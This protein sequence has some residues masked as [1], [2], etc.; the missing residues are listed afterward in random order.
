MAKYHYDEAGNM[1][2]YF[3][4][5]FLALIL[6]PV[7]LLSFTPSK[8][9][10]DGCQC[11]PCVEQRKR[12]RSLSKPALSKKAYFLVFGWS[13]LGYVCY[14]VA[15]AKLDNKIYDPFEILGIKTG[16]AEKEIKS[17]YKKLSKLYHPDKVKATANNTIEAIQN[18]FVE[19]TKAYKSLTD[20]TIRENLEKFGHP[21]GRQDISMG[22]A[23]PQWI[24]E[25][26][27]N[28]W[29]LG[30]YGLL[31]GGA[32]PALVGRW[33]FGSRQK[34]KDGVNALSAAAF[35]KSL[36]E[37]STLEEV[38]GTFGKAFQ[39]ELSEKK[40]KPVP[41]LDQLEKTIKE[42]V[43]SKWDEVKKLCGSDA[44]RRKALVLIYAHL[45]RLDITSS[46]LKTEQ[47]EILLQTPH[48]LS[49][50]LNISISR[51]WLLPTLAI[52]RLHAYLAQALLPGSERLRFA[53]LPG[54]KTD[55]VSTLAPRAQDMG[56]F[57]HALEEKHDGR[58]V[59]VKKAMEK[60]G[61]VEIVDAAF[62][63][64][65]ERVVTPSS[66]VY[67]VLKLR[68]SPPATKPVEE[69]ELDADETKRRIKLND[70]KDE[71]FLTSRKDAEELPSDDLLPGWAHAPYWPGERKPSWWLVLADEKS[72]RVVV[73]PMKITDIPLS[74]PNQ[75]RDYRS[76]KVQFQ[77]PQGVGLFTW[78]VL[79]VSDTFVGEDVSR[80]MPL[81]IEDI[82]TLNAEEPTEDEIS[83]PDEDTIA[84]QMAVMRGG[85]VKKVKTEEDDESDEESST[86][87][88][89]ASES[90]S[91]S[92]SD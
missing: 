80:D 5:T 15:N 28:I 63:V 29:V 16:T 62:K 3:L 23:L 71:E 84:G 61:H 8:K 58:V 83:E 39:W 43:G 2:A 85:T 26:K 53:Q 49:A 79:L 69:K 72:N 35:F 51:N 75:D 4:I 10:L 66:I 64:I 74:R 19:L 52:M 31:F 14:K 82:S 54:I 73:P 46:S 59:D 76:Y 40:S 13:L 20:E 42:R 88:D 24:V 44:S 36:K 77:A 90:S 9:S 7:T 47:R 89:K 60:W 81:K 68:I 45:L 18:R 56:D 86:D 30:I 70:E 22:I 33:W 48:L 12:I 57:V 91:D 1:A 67:L 21:D 34:T 78:K 11:K 92:D 25:R 50:L 87:D 55:E 17:H 32:L 38:I 27:N 37:E 65:G 6:V 41:E